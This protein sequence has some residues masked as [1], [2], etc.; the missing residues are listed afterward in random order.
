[1][2]IRQTDGRNSDGFGEQWTLEPYGFEVSTS[3]PLTGVF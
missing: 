1:M 3:D 2:E